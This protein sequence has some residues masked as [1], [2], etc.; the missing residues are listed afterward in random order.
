MEQRRQHNN[1]RDNIVTKGQNGVHTALE[2]EWNYFYNNYPWLSSSWNSDFK[3]ILTHDVKALVKNLN[4]EDLKYSLDYLQHLNE[5][6]PE[7]KEYPARRFWRIECL[8]T[9]RNIVETRIQNLSIAEKNKSSDF[10]ALV[11]KVL[12][13]KSNTI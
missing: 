11:G 1:F 9:C 4:A 3:S 7:S 5:N 2:N 10:T 8:N 6:V 13:Q 12:V